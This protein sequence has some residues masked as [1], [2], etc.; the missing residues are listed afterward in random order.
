MKIEKFLNSSPIFHAYLLSEKLFV[1]FQMILKKERLTFVQS[2][3]L[4]AIYF[5]E[6]SVTPKALSELLNSS[7]SNISHAVKF[8]RSN[9]LIKKV[10]NNL[11]ER[12]IYLELTNKGEKKV[13]KLI[14][15]YSET[16]DMFESVL[17]ENQILS[18]NKRGLELIKMFSSFLSK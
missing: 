6:E 13:S 12:S 18:W 4:A 16:Q 9:N 8:L 15:L 5:E 1:P 17:S 7:P 3:I 2:M 10:V 11:D 14:S